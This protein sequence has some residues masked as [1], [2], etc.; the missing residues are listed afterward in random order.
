MLFVYSCSYAHTFSDTFCVDEHI[1]LK[2]SKNFIVLCEPHNCYPAEYL[3]YFMDQI[4]VAEM[5]AKIG[6]EVLNDNFTMAFFMKIALGFGLAN[7]E[8]PDFNEEDMIFLI[9]MDELRARCHHIASQEERIAVF[10]SFCQKR[11]DQIAN[12]N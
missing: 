9:E 11:Y 7:D 8:I 6:L 1:M 12:R 4:S 2:F 3:E 10:R 5:E